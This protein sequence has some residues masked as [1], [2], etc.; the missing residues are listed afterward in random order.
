MKVLSL[1]QPYAELIVSGKK[2]IE[3]RLWATKF[4]GEFLIHAG[5]NVSLGAC[6]RFGFD[7]ENLTKGAVVGKAVLISVKEYLTDED[8]LKDSDKHFGSKEGLEEFGWSGKKKYGFVL[9]NVERVNPPI[10]LK[11]QLGFFNYLLEDEKAKNIN[12]FLKEKS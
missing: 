11:G 9:E 8:Y 3:S 10:S 2:T 7:P 12:L 4:R 6:K 5:M 1:R